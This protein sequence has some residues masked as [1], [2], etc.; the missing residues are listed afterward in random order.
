MIL[1][2]RR[3]HR[4]MFAVIGILLPVAFIAGIAARKP[5]PTST[6]PETISAQPEAFT[7]LVWD[8]SDLFPKTTV[9]AQ[10]LRDEGNL[11]RLAVILA[12]SREFAKPDVLVY[13][14]PAETNVRDTIPDEAVLLGAFRP[15]QPLPLPSNDSKQPGLLI[16]YSLADQEIVEVSKQVQ[17][18][19]HSA[20]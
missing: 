2:L 17:W 5:I 10:L 16:L 7:K 19:S 12:A 15:N 8:R 13:W 11:N 3:R 20:M 14:V 4:R 1:P 6:V 9:R 18:P